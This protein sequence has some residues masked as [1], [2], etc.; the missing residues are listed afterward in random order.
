MIAL[1]PQSIS[2]QI[3]EELSRDTV[4][5]HITFV[6]A[7]AEDARTSAKLRSAAGQAQIQATP[8]PQLGKQHVPRHQTIQ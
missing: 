7:L 6:Q 2:N 4:F 3:L 1:L 5:A 8:V